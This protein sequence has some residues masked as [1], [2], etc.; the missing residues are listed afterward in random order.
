M[1]AEKRDA[2]FC[3][4]REDKEPMS[5]K[6]ISAARRKDYR[7][8]RRAIPPLNR[9][10]R[11]RQ[12]LLEREQNLISQL[13]ADDHTRRSVRASAGAN[14]S[15]TSVWADCDQTWDRTKLCPWDLPRWETLSERMKLFAAFD[16]AMEHGWCFPFSAN[17]ATEYVARWESNGSGFMPNIGQRLRREL[18][19]VRLEDLPIC[20]VVETRTRTGKSRCRPHLHGF[21]VCDDAKKATLLKV[22]LE[23][24]FASH[25]RKDK[26]QRAVKVERGYAC[27]QQ[28]SAGQF[29]WVSYIT[30]NVHYY[31]DRLGRRR[32]FLSHSLIDLARTGWAIRREEYS[33][34]A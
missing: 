21:A 24:A 3:Q 12:E 27:P 5:A 13:L 18:A 16:L 31:D 17:I 7:R 22:A 33:L 25:L 2:N 4:R 29:R 32:V 9:Q 26:R 10:K 14:P 28:G 20:Y 15:P 30:K 8:P 6:K 19:K 34:V 1:T 11:E 23:R